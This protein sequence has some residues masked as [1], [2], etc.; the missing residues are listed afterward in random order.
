MSLGQGY[1]IQEV[2]ESAVT[3]VRNLPKEGPIKPSDDLKLRL[4]ACFKQA[5]HGPND[6]P[7]PRFYQIV[8]A[9]KW[10]AW[11][12]LGDMSREE[13]MLSYIRE[14]KQ[15]MDTIPREE[16]DEDDN[17]H[18]E[19]ILGKKFYDY[20]K[21]IVSLSLRCIECHLVCQVVSEVF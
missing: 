3:I 11:R 7:K 21:S 18:F 20:C 19:E 14:L 9:Y 13:A 2:F 15:I 6:T 17:R 5:T 4:Y 1:D 8:E 12:K 10:D 16:T